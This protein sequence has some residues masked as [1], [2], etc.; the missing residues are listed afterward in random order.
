LHFTDETD[1]LGSGSAGGTGRAHLLLAARRRHRTA[2]LHPA[3]HK[4]LLLLHRL[5]DLERA[6]QR[7]I[8][9]HHRARVVKL[10]A[11]VGRAE[12]RHKLPLREE[13]I[14]VLHNLQS[15]YSQNNATQRK[16]SEPTKTTS[17]DNCVEDEEHT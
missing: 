4:L 13:L 3:I 11:V 8:H 7:L 14:A 9:A 12:Q 6:H 1:S 5:Q 2:R 16:R 10:A 17:D 15:R